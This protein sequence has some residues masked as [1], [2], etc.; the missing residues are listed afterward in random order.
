[1]DLTLDLLGTDLL[2]A[3]FWMDVRKAQDPTRYFGQSPDSAWTAFR[4]VV[5]FQLGEAT[6]PQKPLG[7]V[8]TGFLKDTSALSFYPS[9]QAPP[10]A[11]VYPAAGEFKAKK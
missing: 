1:V 5:P 9:G 8:A 6:R 3:T 7:E 2:T 4:K 10:A 11:E